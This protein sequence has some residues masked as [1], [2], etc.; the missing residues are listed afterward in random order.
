LV[1]FNS[2]KCLEKAFSQLKC[3]DE[4]EQDFEAVAEYLDVETK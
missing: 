4:D 2:A 3:A 1:E